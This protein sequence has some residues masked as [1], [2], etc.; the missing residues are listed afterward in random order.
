MMAFKE[1][2][3]FEA[4]VGDLIRWRVKGKGTFDE[5]GRRDV[6]MVLPP[7]K[8]WSRADAKA[9]KGVDPEI[10]RKQAIWRTVRRE[11]DEIGKCCQPPSP[12]L[13]RSGCGN[14]ASFNVANSQLRW[15]ESLMRLV[16]EVQEVVF[17]GKVV[18]EKPRSIRVIKG[19]KDGVREFRYVASFD[20]IVDRVIL[21]R[22]TAYVRDVLEGV[23]GD[24]CYSFRSDPE[25]SHQLAIAKLQEW[26]GEQAVARDA[27]PYR[28][29]QMYVAEC[30]IKKFFDNISH[31]VVRRCWDKVGFVPLAGKVLEAYL[32]VYAANADAQERVPPERWSRDDG[33][34]VPR[35]GLPQ[36]GSFSTVLANLVLH[37]ADEAV[38]AL[39]DG[40][41]FYARYCDDVVIAHADESVC[42]AALEAYKAALARL[43]LPIHPVEPFVY[44]PAD[45]TATDYYTVKS[46]GPFRWS[47]PEVG[48]ANCAPWVSFLGSQ[49]RYDGETRIR[50]ESIERHIRALGRETAKAVREIEKGGV[51]GAPALPCASEWFSRFRNRLIA[52]GVGYVTAKV[53]DCRMCWAGAF[54]RVTDCADTRKQM[55]RLDRVREGMLCK[56]WRML[57]GALGDRALPCGAE[58]G[59]A[60]GD[61]ALPS[62]GQNSRRSA[63]LPRHY[64]GK[65]FSYC[66]FLE[67]AARP[68]NMRSRRRLIAL[69]YSE[70]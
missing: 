59:G 60:L 68:T 36:G 70:L 43:D 9:R 31:D 34:I 46:K 6:E 47:K 64:K 1:Y 52:K 54:A 19:Y 16:D 66:G 14:V 33:H 7:R 5:N 27:R 39:D 62:G 63:S 23:L 45:G 4:I 24:C 30:D 29:P 37:E 8:A 12:R 51:R 15:V 61:R 48:E 65:P 50:K 28:A 53:S 44:R 41:L 55:R 49:V 21:S 67:K 13:R 42:R 56:V 57:G 35:R 40:R 3:S 20:N 32:A 38:E 18:L 58:V 25:M 11:C 10:V 69:P 26:R 17:S 22:T 2:F